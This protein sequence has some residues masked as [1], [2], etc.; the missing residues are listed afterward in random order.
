MSID[1]GK[2][3]VA[4]PT[5]AHAG[6]DDVISEV[7][8]RARTFTIIDI[9]DGKIISI[10]TLDNPAS[11]YKHGSGPIVIKTLVDFNVDAVLAA[12]LGLGASELLNYHNIR[13]ILVKPNTRVADAVRGNLAILEK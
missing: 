10:H 12:E 11:S 3:R 2:V 6:L 5:K 7:F 9:E 8:G 4:V 13:V 1:M